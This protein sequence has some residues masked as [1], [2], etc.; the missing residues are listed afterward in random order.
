MDTHSKGADKS[1]SLLEVLGSVLASMFGVQSN[2]RREEDFAH[3][4]PSQFIIIGLL[5]TV[6][7]VLTVWGVV[8]LVMKLAGL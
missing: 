7:F 6:V 5:V 1:P 2:R 3:G 8:S 4:K